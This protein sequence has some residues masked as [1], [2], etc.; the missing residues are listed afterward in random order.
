MVQ[1]KADISTFRNV[2]SAFNDYER[3]GRKLSGIGSKVI[4]K[5]KDKFKRKKYTE[6]SFYILLA[7]RFHM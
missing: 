4:R 7:Y 2:M 5:F 3:N 1:S 6:L